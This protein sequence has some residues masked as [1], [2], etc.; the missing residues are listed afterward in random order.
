[1]HTHTHTHLACAW[2]EVVPHHMQVVKEC[3]FVL[4][5]M[6]LAHEF[7]SL[8]VNV[9]VCVHAHVR[10]ACVCDNARR[11]DLNPECTTG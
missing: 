10:L 1:M 9:C 6:C 2:Y 3:A 5:R 4:F 7:L 8:C 11:H